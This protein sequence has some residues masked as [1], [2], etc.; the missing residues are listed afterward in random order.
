M[1]FYL[2]LFPRKAIFGWMVP[3]ISSFFVVNPESYTR[4]CFY[5]SSA[6]MLTK[7]DVDLV[8]VRRSGG[9]N[10]HPLQSYTERPVGD[11]IALSGSVLD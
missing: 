3:W 4:H 8:R 6:T 2:D 9:G 1:I 11:K 5:R 10:R 7:S